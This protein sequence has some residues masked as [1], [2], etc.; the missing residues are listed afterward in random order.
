MFVLYIPSFISVVMKYSRC[1]V[2]LC[3]VILKA[4]ASPN[5]DDKFDSNHARLL[6]ETTNINMHMLAGS[7]LKNDLQMLL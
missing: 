6:L 3:T 4:A 5:R 7:L 2:R 1:Q